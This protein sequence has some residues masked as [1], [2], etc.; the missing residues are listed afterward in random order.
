MERNRR[1]GCHMR[2]SESR[3]PHF[4]TRSSSWRPLVPAPRWFWPLSRPIPTYEVPVQR[5]DQTLEG[6]LHPRALGTDSHA[7]SGDAVDDHVRDRL[8]ETFFARVGNLEK[9]PFAM[10][11]PLLAR[12]RPWYSAGAALLTRPFKRPPIRIVERSR[13]AR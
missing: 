12:G 4:E 6:P 9:S 10:L 11:V 1:M 13:G 8:L 3:W 7:I 5:E 2:A